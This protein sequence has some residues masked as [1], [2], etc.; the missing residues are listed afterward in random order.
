M[1]A[2]YGG[3]K[4]GCIFYNGYKHHA[5][6]SHYGDQDIDDTDYFD[7]DIYHEELPIDSD[8]DDDDD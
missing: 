1:F 5:A 2:V 3:C 8:D 6:E 4:S 7:D